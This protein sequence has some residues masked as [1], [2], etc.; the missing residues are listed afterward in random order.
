[1]HTVSNISD[2]SCGDNYTIVLADRG[3]CYALGDN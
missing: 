1:M 3:E 2:F